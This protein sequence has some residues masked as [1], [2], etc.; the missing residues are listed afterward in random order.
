MK[1][2]RFMLMIKINLFLEIVDNIYNNFFVYFKDFIN[3]SIFSYY[4]CNCFEKS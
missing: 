2:N 4:R 1:L 3:T